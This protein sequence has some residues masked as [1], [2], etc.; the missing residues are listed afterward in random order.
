[1]TMLLIVLLL[2][3]VLALVLGGFGYARRGGSQ[4]TTI[5]ED[6]SPRS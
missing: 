4:N 1:M 6:R 5:I 3:V 2:V